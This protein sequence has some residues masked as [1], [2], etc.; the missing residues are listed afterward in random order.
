[1]HMPWR[2]GGGLR[3]IRRERERRC[4]DEHGAHMVDQKRPFRCDPGLGAHNKQ[5][6]QI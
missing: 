2:S 3:A 6:K 1:M 4:T 5:I